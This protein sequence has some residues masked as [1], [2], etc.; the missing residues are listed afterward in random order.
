V[1]KQLSIRNFVLID[2]LDIEFEPG[3]IALTGETGAG[4]S[5][6]L[7][8]LGL[9]LGARAESANVR[10]GEKQADITAEFD[11]T[12]NAAAR[13]WLSAQAE[14]D[15]DSVVLRRVIDVAGK[16]RAQIN[17][18]PASLTE[19]RELGATLLELHAQHEHQALLRGATQRELLDRYAGAESDARAV[20]IAHRT[21]ALAREALAHARTAVVA[22][23]R[24]RAALEL[25]LLELRAAKPSATE[26]DALSVEQSRLSHSKELLEAVD[27]TRAAIADDD[28]VSESVSQLA[29]SLMAAE[30][31]DPML[32]EPRQLIESAR[33]Q[34]DE[35][36][37]SLRHYASKLNL[38]PERL[39]STEARL[40]SLFSLARKLRVRPEDLQA[41]WQ[42]T[43][44]KLARLSASQ[45]VENLEREVA[46]TQNAL[47]VSAAQLSAKR[48]A[49]AQILAAAATAELPD[50]ALPN[51]SFAVNL[52]PHSAIESS[53]AEGIEF[54]FK[55]HASLAFAPIAK[56]ASGGELARLSL[57]I[58]VVCGDAAAVPTLVFDEVDVGVGGR[59]AAL[60][61]RK[62]QTLAANRQVLCVTHM[63]QVAA[64]ADHHF[65]VS[66]DNHVS[67]TTQ[68][69]TLNKKGRLA[70]IARMLGGHEVGAATEKLAKALISTSSR[71]SS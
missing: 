54:T 11:L 45:D 20:Q 38:D 35:A 46:V 14:N 69:N 57:A 23:A 28:G 30:R 42:S 62:L 17:G 65:T 32:A 48:T 39:Q 34:L 58:L 19:M 40:S 33:V 10:A 68:V 16:S 36:A 67:P 53:G 7:D 41:H 26:W 22:I 63:P 61:G 9:A 21:A 3:M 2:R 37:Q 71:L 47:I 44:E 5:I 1:L 60:V 66:R 27:S 52:A 56:V 64:H 8:A 18:R 55:S 15:A 70:E 24:E 25:D 29:S 50:L 49:A 6:V 13:L 12:H 51:A 4:K 59:V 31:I 43:E